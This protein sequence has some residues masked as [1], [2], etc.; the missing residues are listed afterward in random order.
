MNKQKLVEQTMADA[1]KQLKLNIAETEKEE[2][3]KSIL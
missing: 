3:K 1:E 2:L